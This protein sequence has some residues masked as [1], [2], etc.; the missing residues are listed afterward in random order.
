M[1]EP[2]EEGGDAV[3]QEAEEVAQD[4]PTLMRECALASLHARRRGQNV[5]MPRTDGLV[6]CR[7]REGDLP[8]SPMV[9]L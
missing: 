3:P 2:E 7:K 4:P 5:M 8:S 1:A 6:T 9:F